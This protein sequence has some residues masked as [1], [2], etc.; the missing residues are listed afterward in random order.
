[1]G[2]NVGA[3]SAAGIWLGPNEC[4]RGDMVLWLDAGD[5]RSATYAS[6][7]WF[8]L[9]GNNR[10]A[11]GQ[12]VDSA[13][14]THSGNQSF[15]NLTPGSSVEKF[16]VTN[17]FGSGFGAAGWT[18]E[19]WL[20]IDVFDDGGL[21][22]CGQTTNSYGIDF[23][24]TDG[25]SIRVGVRD[26]SSFILANTGT[27]STGVWYHVVGT[28]SST[29]NVK[30]YLGTA[31]TV[32]TLVEEVTGNKS[33]STTETWRIGGRE[34]LAGSADDEFDGK[35]AI[36]RA[37]NTPFATSDIHYNWNCDRGRFL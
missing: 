7:T 11:V 2:I 12:G 5:P 25:N 14:L 8:D 35:I 34:K 6:T 17:D 26:G 30:I 27:V 19:V 22:V 36:V 31:D 13:D 21:V 18:I 9:S 16:H 24:S 33:P 20:K 28:H 23:N 1:M 4:V 10:N 32:P 3:T 37:Y 15:W 29:K